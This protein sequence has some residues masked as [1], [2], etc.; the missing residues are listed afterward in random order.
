MKSIFLKKYGQSENAFEIRETKLPVCGDYDVLIDV[1]CFGLN[2]AEVMARNGLYKA[3][4]PLPCVLG[5]E[6][7]GKISQT[8]KEISSSNIGKRVVA[9]TRFGGYSQQA[10]TPFNACAEIGEMEAGKAT[11]IAVQF[12]TAYYM[13]YEMCNIHA[14]DKVLIHAA[15][16]GVGTALIQLCKL[17]GAIVYA[18]AG[19]D[20]KIS[21][22]KS[23]GADETLN[24]LKEDYSK[25]Y[26]SRKIKFDVIFNPVAGSTF[27]KDYLLLD[28][29]G[30][31]VLFGASER[32]GKKFGILSTLNFLRKMGLMIP[33]FLVGKSK[34]LIGV[35]MLHIGDDKPET[36]A[37]CMRE[38]AALVKEGKLH[39]QVGATF[40]AEDIAKAHEL[41]ESRKSTGKIAV[42][43]Q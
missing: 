38:V 13:A 19:D 31:L 34:S 41:L 16:G 39:P 36:L 9:F 15:A 20:K 43:W 24:Y 37:R 11:C 3:A 42:F 6:V 35:N 4:P 21:Y 10:V 22:L 18:N 33:I 30:R 25:V 28:T 7:V 2:Y 17:K 12:A 23:Q 40:K 26:S 8:G 32:S 29:G 27:K 5:Y 14:G 1:E